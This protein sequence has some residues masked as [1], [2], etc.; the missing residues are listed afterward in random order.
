MSQLLK[1]ELALAASKSCFIE[2][3]IEAWLLKERGSEETEAG[4]VMKHTRRKRRKQ[5]GKGVAILWDSN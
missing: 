4:L 5:E 1:E 2:T 3:K